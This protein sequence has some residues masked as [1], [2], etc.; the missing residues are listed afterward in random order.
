MPTPKDSTIT[1]RFR[2]SGDRAL[3]RAIEELHL[4]QVR[5]EKGTKAYDKAVRQLKLDKERLNNEFGLGVKNSRLLSNSFATL[6]SKLL[7]VSFGA[8]I[9]AATVGRLTKLFAEQE[10]AEK[11]LSTALGFVSQELLNFA[12]AMQEVTTF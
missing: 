12:S 7:L 2:A 1:V 11:R 4:A 10:A 3:K 9:A 8:G 5:L 6:R